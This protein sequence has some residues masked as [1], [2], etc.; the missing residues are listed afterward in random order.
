MLLVINPDH[1]YFE[2]LLKKQWKY[3]VKC[4]VFI[5][6]D[7]VSNFSGTVCPWACFCLSRILLLFDRLPHLKVSVRISNTVLLG[8][9]ISSLCHNKMNNLF[10]RPFAE[11][12]NYSSLRLKVAHRNINLFCRRFCHFMNHITWKVWTLNKCNKYGKLYFIEQTICSLY[13]LP[14][15]GWKLLYGCRLQQEDH[16]LDLQV[17][18]SG[19]FLCGFC[20]FS[21]CLFQFPTIVR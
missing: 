1:L 6:A 11:L 21:V 19:F 18:L 5:L 12:L 4:F 20:I 8:Q 3:M 10:S 2:R 13:I 14:M 9:K 7:A 17:G 15:I 16:G